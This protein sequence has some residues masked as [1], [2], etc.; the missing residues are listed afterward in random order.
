MSATTSQPTR[1]LILGGGFG[2]VATAQGL[3][4][5]FRRDQ[6]VTITL[7]NRDNHF[8]YVPLL[9]SAAAGSIE[10]LHVVAPLRA[11]LHGVRFR[12]E[13]VLGVDLARRVVTTL[14]P[15]TGRERELAYDHLVLALGNVIDLA[16]L[17]GVAQHGMTLKTLG[18]AFAIR[19]HVLAMLEAA[20][21]ETDPVLRREMVTFVIA[22]GG[23]SGVEMAGELNDLVREAV[24]RQ[25]PS[26]PPDQPRVI[27]L[28]SQGRILPEMSAGIA[29][30]ALRQLRQR[31][32]EVQLNVRLAR[33]TPHAAILNDGARIPTRTLIVAVG[34]A[35]PPVLTGLPVRQER[36]CI[37]VDEAM[38]VPGAPGV[39][40]LGDNALVPNRAAKDGT[41]SPPT[42]QYALRQGR[43][44][45]WNIAAAIRG[46]QLRP[47]AFGGLGLLCLVGHGAGVGELPGGV[48]VRGRLG[49]L[50]WRSVYWSKLPTFGRKL[51]VGAG[52]ALDPLVPVDTAQLNLGRTQ[53]I[54]QAH[55]DANEEIFRQGDPGDHFYLIARGAVEIVREHSSGQQVVLARLGP[56]EYFGETALLSKRPRNATARCAAPTDVVTLG[57]DDFA[58]LAGTWLQFA[59]TLRATSDQR[60]EAAPLTGMFAL[61]GVP[62]YAPAAASAAPP[63]ACLVRRDS[64]GE[65]ALDRDLLSLGRSAENNIVVPDQGVSRRHALIQRE[66]DVYWLEDLGATNGTYVNGQRIQERVQLRHGDE[67]A[68][69][70]T[71]F[72]F[73]A[74]GASRQ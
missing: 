41:P 5:Q 34:N 18:D 69:G 68:V 9:A 57:R 17:P 21:V 15:E 59:D 58:T 19:N 72:S 31:G 43:Q 42:A 28:H 70:G 55:Y 6:T 25:Y 26:I 14:A 22:G 45:A 30:Y 24:H 65:I 60:V 36:G 50:L 27:L 48:R 53:T 4:R 39:W 32:V 47:F 33:A 35:P 3:A 44:L 56:G 63:A 29:D 54:G 73:A 46:Q 62:Q 11:M 51:Q 38:R 8:V 67:I 64:A 52:W 49:W 2:G 66:G 16:K 71:A 23:F 10:T 37:V 61:P 40:A 1:I 74:S 20:D 12:A 7:V 13:E